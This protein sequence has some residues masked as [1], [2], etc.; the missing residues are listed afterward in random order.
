[1]VNEKTHE[2]Q[3]AT[4][5]TGKDGDKTISAYKKATIVD[6]VTYENLTPGK[7][8]TL[9]GTLMNK[10]TERAIIVDGKK[11]TAEKTFTPKTENGTVTM[12]FT[13]DARE[14]KGLDIVVFEKLY[15]GSRII[16]SH[17]EI[18]DQGQTVKIGGAASGTEKPSNEK[19]KEPESEKGK[20]RIPK[21]GDSS[22]MM[23][24]FILTVLAAA[25]TI[26]LAMQHQKKEK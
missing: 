19:K 21:T 13:F 24:Y 5:A 12:T 20:S 4:T 1:M 6:T 18:T 10:D 3:I 8:Y 22:Q 14:L 17:E 7:T 9:K 11:V 23:L 25:A 16:A 26:F 2:P 15:L